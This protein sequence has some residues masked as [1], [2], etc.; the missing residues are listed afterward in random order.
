MTYSCVKYFFYELNKNTS[1]QALY[2]FKTE[3]TQ[4]SELSQIKNHY[5]GIAREKENVNLKILSVLV[6]NV[7][8]IIYFF[9][10]SQCKPKY[11]FTLAPF[12]II[13]TR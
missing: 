6:V 4:I 10:S 9:L 11:S 5:G 2:K 12:K 8:C 13:Y 3:L 7:E 1:F